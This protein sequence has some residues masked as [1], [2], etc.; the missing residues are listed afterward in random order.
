MHAA[1]LNEMLDFTDV[2]MVSAETGDGLDLLKDKIAEYHSKLLILFP[3]PVVDTTL[4]D[5]II[6]DDQ[7]I[8]PAI[9]RA[10]DTL[11]TENDED[12]EDDNDDDDDKDDAGVGFGWE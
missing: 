8:L 5:S 11:V 9:V 3:P 1:R 2:L 12:E 10:N 6:L 7:G 4:R